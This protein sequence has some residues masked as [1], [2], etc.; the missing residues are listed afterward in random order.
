MQAKRPPIVAIMGHVDH[1][2][3]T[4]LDYIRKTNVAGKEAGGITQS[5]GA[6]EITIPTQ[7][8]VG[9][10][11]RPQASGK[12]TFID[13]PGHEAFSKMRAYGAQIADLAILVVA[14]DDG[15]KPQTINAL[16]HIQEAKIPFVVAINKTDKPNADIEKAKMDLS[17][18][19]VNLE[20]FGGDISWHGISAK[21]G[22]GVNDLLDLV[23]LASEM[24]NL[25]YDTEET[26]SGVILSAR[27]DPQRGLSVGVVL[28][29]GILG[30]G[31]F[32]GAG[33]T[34]GKIK[35]LENFLGKNTKTLEPSA[36]AIVMGFEKLPNVGETFFAGKD[37]EIVTK[38]ARG[39]LKTTS[40]GDIKNTTPQIP[41]EKNENE[42]KIVVKADEAA[43]L[44]VL[45]DLIA[46]I[47]ESEN[48]LIKILESSVGNIHE[49]DV[50]TADSGE[51]LIVSFRSKPD[52]AAKNLAGAKKVTIL[53]F[54]IIYE[55]EDSLRKYIKSATSKERR[56]L[57]V[58]A[59]FGKAKGKERIVGGKILLGPV[60][61]QETFEVWQEKR[62]ICTGRIINLQ[63]GRKD[64]QEAITNQEVGMLVES[65][66]PIKVG[67]KLIFSE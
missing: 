27:M 25:T 59:V 17:I 49:G 10:G 24:E 4:L 9:S 5:M 34:S 65:E 6:Y 40:D 44:E 43:S 21:T 36:P 67:N 53:A 28:R 29:N 39:I 37:L 41:G 12:I 56:A 60:K 31:Q 20:G 47:A 19:G 2:K 16:K 23:L 52:A 57:E 8:Q 64:I 54:Q 58:L 61:N 14:A 3:T 45:L 30:T 48:S 22:E 26:A 46:R 42:I 1:G 66:E 38:L 55:L 15:V 51:A 50:K 35:I 32:I 11:P 18:N 63:S 62:L 7:T 13:T 33:T